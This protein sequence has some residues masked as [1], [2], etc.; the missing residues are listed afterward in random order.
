MEAHD[1]WLF[2]HLLTFVYW[3]G[4]D[5]GV[6]YSSRFV[7]NSSYQPA[8]RALLLKTL[9]W[10]DMVPR[11]ALLLTLPVGLRLAG[12]LNISPVSGGSF[13]LV[14]L[15]LIIWVALVTQIH[16]R[17]GTEAAK[18]L[19]KIDMV[20]R[21]VLVVVLAVTAI[22]SLSGSAIYGTD[23]LAVKVLLFAAAVGCGFM[24]RITFKPFGPA[25]AAIMKDGSTPEQETKLRN[26]LNAAARWVVV[27]WII[28]AAAAFFGITQLSF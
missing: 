1:F 14:W 10:L 5:L 19:A 21:F 9:A 20:L 11:Y 16:R 26:S 13:W 25:F 24:I 18:T 22:M 23:W 8:T 3:M 28:I 2:L 7:I 12:D 6:F 17:E 4:A 27:L 15:G